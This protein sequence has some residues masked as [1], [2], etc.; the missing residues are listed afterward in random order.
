MAQK[1][2]FGGLVNLSALNKVLKNADTIVW[3]RDGRIDHISDGHFLVKCYLPGDCSA[4][5]TLFQRFGRVPEDGKAL[6]WT[7]GN[8]KDADSIDKLFPESTPHYVVDTGLTAKLT[9]RTARIFC[10]PGGY[11]TVDTKYVDIIDNTLSKDIETS[12]LKDSAPLVFFREY[13]KALLLPIRPYGAPFLQYLK[14]M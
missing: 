3:Q 7:N 4:V 12:D 11:V 9:A 13:E 6:R 5:G 10:T 2:S 1:T 14:T 8:V